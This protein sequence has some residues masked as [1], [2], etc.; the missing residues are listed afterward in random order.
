MALN[1]VVNA[2]RLTRIELNYFKNVSH[3]EVVLESDKRSID[4]RTLVFYGQNGSGKTAVIEA[5]KVLKLALSG[6]PIPNY[7]AHLI[8]NGEE[9]AQLGY[10]FKLE[11]DIGT[12]NFFYEICIGREVDDEGYQSIKV[13]GERLAWRYKLADKVIRKTNLIDTHDEEN[14][15]IPTVRLT[16]LGKG[17]SGL[18]ASKQQ[19]QLYLKRH[20]LHEAGQSF[21]FSDDLVTAAESVVEPVSDW[22]MIGALLSRLKQFGL[23]ELFVISRVPT[24]IELEGFSAAY[25]LDMPVPSLYQ[26]LSLDI[27]GRTLTVDQLPLFKEGVSKSNVVF[28]QLFPGLSVKVKEL[29]PAFDRYGESCVPI[30]LVSCRQGLEVDLEYESKGV[31]RI[32]A[33]LHLLIAACHKRTFT[34]AIDEIDAGLFECLLGELLDV[35]SAKAKGQLILTANNQ[36]VLET[37]DHRQVVFTTTNKNQRYVRLTNVN[38]TK[39]L[40]DFYYREVS[41]GDGTFYAHTNAIEIAHAFKSAMKAS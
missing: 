38:R 39:N 27:G 22:H 24:M 6:R 37:I 40:R 2:L 31:N 15:F 9:R 5:L 21:V 17:L 8:E 13:T 26:L 3:G 18:E 19:I 7:Y 16:A 11:A 30:Q 12:V 34:V 4:A 1:F 20:S 23:K 29:G 14:A 28:G 36:R 32:F 10:D 41:L 35:L 25:D 33:M